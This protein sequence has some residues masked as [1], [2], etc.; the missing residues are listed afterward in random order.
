MVSSMKRGQAEVLMCRAAMRSPKHQPLSSEPGSSRHASHRASP[1]RAKRSASDGAATASQL[2]QNGSP[3]S[4]AAETE[5]AGLLEH[6]S[7]SLHAD[8]TEL[9][10]APQHEGLPAPR[11]SRSL[12]GQLTI[13]MAALLWGTR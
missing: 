8:E 4:E 2:A 1:V 7:S 3:A 12:R 5:Q 6:N 11:L 10:E 9:G 13:L